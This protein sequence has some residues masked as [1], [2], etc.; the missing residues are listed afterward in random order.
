MT[1]LL[2]WHMLTSSLGWMGRPPPA[3]CAERLAITSLAFMLVDV[4]EPVWKTSI[5]K[6]AS[7]L[8]SITSCAARWMSSAFSGFEQPEILIDPRGGEFDQARAPG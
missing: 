7:H 8:P 5:G 2:L 6:S 4:P 3:S 1:S